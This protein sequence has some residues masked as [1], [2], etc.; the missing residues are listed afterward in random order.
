VQKLDLSAKTRAEKGKQVKKLRSQG[1]IPAVVYAPKFEE[2]V[3]AVEAKSFR[4]VI[5]GAAGTNVIINLKVLDDGKAQELPVITYAIQRD[6]LSDEIIHVDFRK[7]SMTEKIK[8]KVQV[9]LLGEPIGVKE[10]GGVLV[11]G[12]RQI[13]VECLPG[14]IPAKFS[15]DVSDL[16]INHS[17]RVSDLVVPEDVAVLSGGEELIAFVSTASKEEVPVTPTAEAVLAEGE[18]APAAEAA[19]KPG[20]AAAKAGQA[21]AKAGQ[22]GA[23]G[24]APEAVP[25]SGRQ[26]AKPGEKAAPAEGKIAAK[27][28]V[29]APEKK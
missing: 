11:H 4:K 19:G 20:Q 16:T 12:L 18:A 15:I 7:I 22:A 5:A 24:A 8:T 13:E 9:E 17:K 21:A 2:L 29:K 3:V 28:A 25:Q 14:N 27:P 6:P 1:L 10:E 23:E 26:A